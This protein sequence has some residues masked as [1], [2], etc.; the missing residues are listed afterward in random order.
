MTSATTLY[1]IQKGLVRKL[2]LFDKT[3]HQV[4]QT[5]NDTTNA[6][7]VKIGC[8]AIESHASDLLDQL[9]TYFKLKRKAYTYSRS[10]GEVF[11]QTPQVDFTVMIALNQSNPKE[12]LLTTEINAFKIDPLEAD[13]ALTQIFDPYCNEITVT[14]AE[15]ISIEDKIDAIETIEELSSALNYPSDASYCT[16]KF[17]TINLQI[18]IQPES[19]NLQPLIP[20]SLNDFL[21]NANEAIN[22]LSKADFK[23][24]LFEH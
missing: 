5:Y 6:F 19:L 24:S 1:G 7:V 22:L 13:P 9:R 10:P 3:K 15:A 4:P 21:S 18:T 16:L 12:Y 14:S 11:V 20:K 23:L 17:Q 8:E 2:S